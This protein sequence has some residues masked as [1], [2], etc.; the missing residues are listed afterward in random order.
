MHSHVSRGDFMPAG[1]RFTTLEQ[2]VCEELHMCSEVI[3]GECGGWRGSDRN[4]NNE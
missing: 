1:T 4:L 2:V 3:R